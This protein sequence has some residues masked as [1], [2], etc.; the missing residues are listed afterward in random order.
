ML[1]RSFLFLAAYLIGAIPTGYIV[2]KLARN[3]DIRD[4][5]SGNIGFSNVY[6][7]EGVLLGALV[8]V[9]DVGKA[10]GSTYFFSAVFQNEGLA[11]VLM[12]IAVILGNIFTPFLRFKGGKGVATT[13]GVTLA[14]NPFASLCALAAFALTVKLTRYMSLGS[15]AGVAVYA[16]ASLL[17]YTFA[18]YDVYSLV[19]AIIV[20]IVIAIRHISNI[21]RLL[22]GQE[23]RIGSGQRS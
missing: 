3:R 11:R 5:G 15:L 22:H 19:F 12:G 18:G 7:N 21:K 16:L 10:F 4:A 2:V 20:L 13:L 23:N 8:L 17:F 14:L 9:I 6:R 1:F